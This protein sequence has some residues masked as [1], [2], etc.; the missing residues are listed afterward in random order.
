MRDC[1]LLRAWIWGSFFFFLSLFNYLFPPQLTE[2]T[3]PG[4]SAMF[5]AVVDWQAFWVYSFLFIFAM[6]SD[7]LSISCTLTTRKNEV[8]LIISWLYLVKDEMSLATVNQILFL[9]L[10][11]FGMI[12]KQMAFLSRVTTF[13]LHPLQVAQISFLYFA[14][15]LIADPVGLQVKYFVMFCTNM[16]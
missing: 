2:Q 7:F 16:R 3:G 14:F 15:S 6:Y 4:R 8:C 1:A 10:D 5:I 9:W 12:W 11:C 13:W